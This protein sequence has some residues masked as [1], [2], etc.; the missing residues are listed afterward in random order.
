M[1]NLTKSRQPASQ[2]TV[3]YLAGRCLLRF[4][5]AQQQTTVC[6]LG[7]A[8]TLGKRDGSP[9]HKMSLTMAMT[10]FTVPKPAYKP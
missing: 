8:S 7:A 1:L 3:Q 10:E 6:A 2:D 5:A 4:Y 9:H